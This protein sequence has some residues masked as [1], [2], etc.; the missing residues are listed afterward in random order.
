MKDFFRCCLVS[1]GLGFAVGAVITASNKN[2]QEAAKQAKT[3]A[4]EKIEMAK[5]GFETVKEKVEE[6]ISDMQKQNSSKAKSQSTSSA[7][8]KT[9]S[10]S[11]S[12]AKN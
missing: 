4:M 7:K 10:Q 1:M 11:K 6:S 9:A 12:K 8:K 2:V 3:M 5:D